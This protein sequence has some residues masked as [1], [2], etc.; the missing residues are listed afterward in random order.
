VNFIVNGVDVFDVLK[1][2]G[3]V[4]PDI[5]LEQM[6]KSGNHI[7]E[8]QRRALK[9][10]HTNTITR[11]ANGK[12]YLSRIDM[13]REFGARERHNKDD[14]PENMA[15]FITSFTMDASLVT[16][17]NGTHGQFR[18]II[19]RDGKV[20]GVGSTV[21]GVSK[22]THAILQKMNDGRILSDYP[23]RTQLS[24]HNIGTHY[25][26]VGNNRSIPKV[27]QYL[28]KGYKEVMDRVI[29]KNVKNRTINL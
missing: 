9:S 6:S 12:T 15:S 13:A 11:E 7:R 28:V 22:Q 20:V 10:T 14:N 29:K 5:A 21:K 1:T 2:M 4:A 18:P 26:D 25:A 17:V 16:V 3:D 19:R 8:N 27:S 24:K 23:T